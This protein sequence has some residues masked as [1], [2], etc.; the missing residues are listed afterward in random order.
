LTCDEYWMNW[1][2]RMLA[3][4]TYRL[5]LLFIDRAFLLTHY[6]CFGYLE[7]SEGYLV[8]HSLQKTQHLAFPTKDQR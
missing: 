2:I 8:S 5:H 1:F 3:A 6:S 7:A 4:L